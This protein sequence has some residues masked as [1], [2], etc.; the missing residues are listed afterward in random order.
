MSGRAALAAAILVAWIAGLALFARR[1]LFRAPAQRLA[2]AALR[3]SPGA[4][5]FI[6]EQAGSRVG[7]ASS[8]ID[9]VAS[10]LQVT[11]YLVADLP[12]GGSAH[13]ATAQSVVRLSRALALRDFRISFE[14]DGAPIAVSGRTRGDTLLEYVLT[15]GG[16]EGDTQHVRLSAPLLLPTLVPLAVALG[17][18]P[19]VGARHTISTFDPTAMAP[20]D[21]VISVLAESLFVVSDSAAYDSIA[22]QWE[23]AHAD[24]VR[25]W[26]I[27]SEG[28]G[29]DAW[30]DEQG[31]IVEARQSV[32]FTL[33]RT[34]YELAF[35]NW[36]SARP[37]ARVS[38]ER[39]MFETTAIAASASLGSRPLERL[40]VRLGTVSPAG[41]DL[42]SSRQT[43]NGDTLTVRREPPSALAASYR[44]PT[45]PDVR[46]RFGRD[47]AAAPLLERDDPDIRR[48]AARIASTVADR[49]D[50]QLVARAINAWV[51]DSLR[52]AITISVPS[53]RQVLR[54]RSGDC[55]EHTQLFLALA[56][57][58]GIPARG[59]AGLAY[60]DGKFY[61]HA[62]PEIF[63]GDWVAVDPT[64][65]QFPADASHLRF[66]SGGITRQGE[67]LRLM[68]QL[69]LD[70]LRAQ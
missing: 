55:N 67:L 68:G 42:R 51:H 59:A 65:G 39:D 69:R 54:A 12:I 52:K 7:F 20:R 28:G 40:S 27:A 47:L 63:L 14:S 30:I 36:R 21:L 34:A 38:A 62:W 46:R 4:S 24:T 29:L 37:G 3:I 13:R 66:I 61:Y 58:A 32:G 17:E 16:A 49:T 44:L 43:L 10:G 50:P 41:F 33:R 9:T 6:V 1:E 48:L 26:R 35:E 18:R 60:V 64:F 8:T 53:A 2:E 70:V 11:D 57:S 23:P 31:R 25:A 19:E 5:Y 15:S 45:P 56:R 22:R